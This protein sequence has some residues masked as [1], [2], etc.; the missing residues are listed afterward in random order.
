VVTILQLIIVLQTFDLLF[1]LTQG[2][3][4]T[5]TTVVIYYIF[6]T[7]F[8]ELNLGYSAA[9]A[10][11]LTAIIA[12]C[13]GFLIVARVRG[14]RSRG[15]GEDALSIQLGVQQSGAQP[16][17]TRIITGPF[18]PVARRQLHL[19]RWI[20]TAAVVLGGAFL[21]VWSI[22]PIAWMFIASLQPEGAVTSVPLQLTLGLRW[23]NYTN[24]FFNPGQFTTLPWLSSTWVSLQVAVLA[25]A[26]TIVASALIAYPLARLDV[27]GKGL[28]M[29][30]LI[31]TQMVP[32]IVLAIPVLLIFRTLGLVDTIAGLVIVNVAFS[33]PVIAWLLRN[34]F[35][36][37]PRS[38]ESAARIDGCSRLG[39]L[40]RVTMHAA[41]P[42]IAAA[43]ILMLIGTW[44]EFLFAV[45]LGNHDAVT[46]TR[47]IGLVNTTTG[48]MGRPPYTQVAAAGVVAIAPCVAL[49]VFFYRQIVRGLT[50]GYVKG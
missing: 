17:V 25:T 34:A 42:G 30:G 2:G 32:A 15:P 26:I 10:V 35:E 41:R 28:F 21:V 48:P 4:G 19:P 5:A 27:P 16:D 49:V 9:I 24:L 45:V 18:P 6:K 40:F 36:E 3:P 47:L 23:T 29:G 20:G 50:A 11:F 33:I 12:L 22:G 38:I 14:R 46:V 8:E 44:N 7:A 13:T 39:T 1:T 37:V 31:A 43:A